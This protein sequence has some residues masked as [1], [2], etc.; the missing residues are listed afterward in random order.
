MEEENKLKDTNDEKQKKLDR[1]L[2]AD[3]IIYGQLGYADVKLSFILAANI[4]LIVGAFGGV[5]ECCLQ[6]ANCENGCA[7]PFVPWW[8]ICIIAAYLFFFVGIANIVS[9]IFTIQGLCPNT[10]KHGSKKQE[11]QNSEMRAIEPKNQFFYGDVGSYHTD[12]HPGE[13]KTESSLRKEYLDTL[14][15]RGIDGSI[16]DAAG[17]NIAVSNILLSKY[18]KT[19]WSVYFLLCSIFPIWYFI[20]KPWKGTKKKEHL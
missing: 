19:K 11:D 16:E 9:A 2:K 14:D 4:G 6:M 8:G 1:L 10:N 7:V 17:Q 13:G 18:Q 20:G 3:D 15:A 12:F 5:V